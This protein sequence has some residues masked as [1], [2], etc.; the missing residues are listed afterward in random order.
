MET[1]EGE[2]K[3]TEVAGDD[4]TASLELRGADPETC[5]FQVPEPG[6]EA[7][8]GFTHQ[9]QSSGHTLLYTHPA[10]LS[11]E[12]FSCVL[13]QEPDEN[14][15]GRLPPSW[16][17]GLLLVAHPQQSDRLLQPEW[18]ISRSVELSSHMVGAS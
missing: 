2:T 11:P 13:D 4:G 8:G 18:M 10:D 6:A 16:S 15:L 14:S 17:S 9:P 1:A 3:G 7:L 12:D 5:F